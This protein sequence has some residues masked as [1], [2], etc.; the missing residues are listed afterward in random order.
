[1]ETLIMIMLYLFHAYCINYAIPGQLVGNSHVT[2]INFLIWIILLNFFFQLQIIYFAS[3]WSFTSGHCNACKLYM[4][5]KSFLCFG[6]REILYNDIQFEHNANLWRK[7]TLNL[8]MIS[9]NILFTKKKMNCCGLWYNRI[10]ISIPCV[11]AI[12]KE[13]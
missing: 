1:M 7:E 8:N 6:R 9:M 13:T 10:A 11:Q 12:S 4:M 3:F 2:C 5:R